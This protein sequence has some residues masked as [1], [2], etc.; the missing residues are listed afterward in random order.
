[1]VRAPDPLSVVE[2][3]Y[4]LTT[5][6]SEWISRLVAVV[7]QEITGPLG[8]VGYRFEGRPHLHYDID[9]VGVARGD[10]I[11]G[12]LTRQVVHLF[13]RD[14]VRR[15]Y[16]TRGIASSH[17][18]C[19]TPMPDMH[20][21][22]GMKDFCG[23]VIGDETSGVTIGTPLPQPATLDRATRVRWRRICAHWS[24][25]LRLRSALPAWDDA[26]VEAVLTP[27]ARVVHAAGAARPRS[28][29]DALRR[30]VTDMERAR[31][32]LRRKDASGALSL[33]RE[34]IAGR[35]T[36]VER[37]ETDGR[38]FLV[39]H[40]NPP[41]A[42]P[43]RELTPRQ[44]VIVRL[45]VEGRSEARIASELGLSPG[46]ISQQVHAVLRKFRLR[47]RGAL[48]DLACRLTRWGAATTSTL[49]GV[50][51]CVVDAGPELDAR[52]TPEISPTQLQIAR[53]LLDG[54]SNAEIAELRRCAPQTIANQVAMLYEKL[55]VNSRT[56][57]GLRL[58]RA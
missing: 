53:F 9:V 3:G 52:T 14:D 24:A 45:L 12:T 43:L 11:L 25:L 6:T 31:G 35:W 34:L 8:T 56:E 49:N 26:R 2:A 39:A 54:L 28:A 4:D 16:L 57:L 32:S 18:S 13:P 19:V 38:R 17:E 33:W 21:T 55:G 27:D 5:S 37:F 47:G 46:A 48:I 7:A 51:T 58:L 10:A 50:D 44:N 40:A 30:A 1:M 41:D 29:R 23:I 42:V 22:R 15:F 20:L 36:L